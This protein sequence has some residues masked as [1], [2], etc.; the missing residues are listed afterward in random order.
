MRNSTSVGESSRPRTVPEAPATVS[1]VP[2][3]GVAFEA[4]DSA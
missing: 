2:V 3:I 1:Q 4:P